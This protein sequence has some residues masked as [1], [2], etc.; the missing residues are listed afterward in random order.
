MYPDTYRV[1]SRHV[2]CRSELKTQHVVYMLPSNNT[3][4]DAELALYWPVKAITTGSTPWNQSHIRKGV[5]NE[6]STGFWY[7]NVHSPGTYEVELR[8]WPEEANLAINSGLKPG[9]PVPG[10]HAY[11]ETPGREFSTLDTAHVEI[12]GKKHSSSFDQDDVK[13]KF[14][15]ELPAGKTKLTASFTG[16]EDQSVGAYYAYVTRVEN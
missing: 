10:A 5:D 4:A 11:R 1:R 2:M 6:K 9:A 12:F 3:M 14:R 15:I 8:R 13:A 7:V 16:P